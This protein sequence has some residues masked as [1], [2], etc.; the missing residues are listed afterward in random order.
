[1]RPQ[2]SHTRRVPSRTWWHVLGFVMAL[3]LFTAGALSLCLLP[4]APAHAASN[5]VTDPG[6]P[7][8]QYADSHWNCTDPSCSSTVAEGDAQPNFQC[9]EFV[10][11]SLAADGLIPGLTQDSDQSAY[12]YYKAQNGQNYDLLWVGWT[13]SDGYD[14]TPGLYQFLT[15]TGLASDIGN[16]PADAAPGDVVIY[17]EGD[18]HTGLLIQTGTTVNGSDTIIDAHN[19]ARYHAPYELYSSL[20]ILHI[21]R[22]L[23]SSTSS[24]PVTA[25]GANRLDILGIGINNATYHNSWYGSAWSG[26]QDLGGGVTPATPDPVIVSWA[27]NRLDVFVI[28]TDHSLYHK[29]WNGSSWS[30]SW[31]NLGGNLISNPAVV[32]WGPNRL[33]IFGVGTDHALYHNSWYGS[34]WSG[35][36]DLGGN[37]NTTY[38]TPTVAAWGPNRLDVFII[39]AD[40]ALYHKAWNGSSWSSS[41]QDL[42]GNLR[43]NPTA[44]SWGPN[45]LDI[46]AAGTDHALYH[47]SWY[48]SAWSGWQ[49][50]G[51][52]IDTTYSTPAVTSW[53]SNR[54]DVFVV[55]ADNALYHKDWNGSSWSSSWQDLGGDLISNPAVASWGPNRLDMFGVGA[56]HALYHKAWNG[57]A[58]SDW[59]DEGGNIA[60]F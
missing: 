14:T 60:A 4:A 36:Q 40:A 25:W 51:G 2:T 6:D 44:I 28:G 17:H 15:D 22:H 20:T 18:G 23:S 54:L 11:R 37:V 7:A 42:G 46:F 56:D 8:I 13:S 59:Q 9:A 53:A 29:A 10:S 19:N 30:S 49:N 27:S 31:E 43:S 26:W 35:W 34:G 5:A 39:G 58:Y 50:M 32:S 3:L 1:M 21:H 38:S 16:D 52:N 33:D 24:S 57:S 45:R 47:I 12:Q 48:G 41:W 55:G